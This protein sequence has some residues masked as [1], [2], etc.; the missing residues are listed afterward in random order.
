MRLARRRP[1]EG[2]S[3]VPTTGPLL[4]F[5]AAIGLALAHVLVAAAP[6]AEFTRAEVLAAAER[7]ADWQLAHPSTRWKP[8]EWHNGALYTGIM[9]LAGISASPRFHDAMMRMGEQQQWQLGPRPYHA[10]DHCIGQ[11]FAELYLQ[12]RD[13]RMIGPLR[14]RF[15]SIL[16][17]PKRNSLDFDRISN[18]DRQG[19]WSW[20]DALFMSP[21]AWLR[22]WRATDDRRYLDF[23]VTE[24]WVTSDYLYSPED[25]LYF[26]D[27]SYF[28]KREKNG[29]RVFWSRGNGWVMGGLVRMLQLLPEDHPARPRFEQQFREMAAKVLACRQADGLW[30]ASLLDPASY[31]MKESSGSGF[32]CYALAWGVNTGRLDRATYEPKVRGTWHALVGC[33]AADGRLTHVQP[34]GATPVTFDE[35]STEPYGVG[36]FLLAASEVHR[37]ATP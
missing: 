32:F 36:A 33:L 18:P 11:T 3:I 25:H 20:C 17:M 34:V 12:H 13:P 15:D 37:L 31:P 27:S 30:R 4:G 21:P 26:R 6:T 29:A 19:R 10:D 24:W 35:N 8:H 16:A 9:A 7:A 2:G 1:G 23:A 14:E 28:D 22:L 5:R